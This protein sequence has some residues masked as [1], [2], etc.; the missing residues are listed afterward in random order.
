MKSYKQLKTCLLKNRAIRE[1]YDELGPEFDIITLLIKKRI[2]NGL[3]QAELAER[4]GTKQSAVSRLE[5]GFYNPT[6]GFLQKVARG[7]DTNI[8]VSLRG[9]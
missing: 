9:K 4:I 7:L 1:T 5:S 2:E 3:T 8:S 6:L